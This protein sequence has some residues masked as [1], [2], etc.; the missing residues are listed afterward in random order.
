MW[1][2]FIEAVISPHDT[3]F[4]NKDSF[5]MNFDLGLAIRGKNAN[6]Q[7]WSTIYSSFSDP[8]ALDLSTVSVSCD[9]KKG[10][11]SAQEKVC[12]SFEVGIIG[13]L[14]FE[15]YD[16]AVM[17]T[18]AP[19][20]LLGRDYATISF[21][22]SHLSDDFMSWYAVTRIICLVISAS[23]IFLYFVSS[24]SLRGFNALA[25]VTFNLD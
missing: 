8:K 14:N 17:I 16:I 24:C 21:R 1:Q 4:T 2:I 7:K 9:I 23:F 19:D 3:S 20:D 18:D 15:M 13:N 25:C 22:M 6:D 5:T 12:D 10:D 11:K